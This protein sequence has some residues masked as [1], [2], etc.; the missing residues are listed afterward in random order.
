MTDETEPESADI[1]TTETEFG[2]FV[3]TPA[4]RRFVA[5]YCECMSGAEAARRA[6]YSKTTA[7][8]QASY[9]LTLPQIREAIE[10]RFRDAAAANAVT[11]EKIVAGAAHVAFLDPAKLYDESGNLKPWSEIDPATRQA[12]ASIE[13][14]EGEK[15]SSR[16][17]RFSDRMSALALLAKVKGLMA[18]E[19]IEVSGPNGDPI[20]LLVHQAQNRS[21]ITPVATIEHERAEG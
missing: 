16:R 8:K 20:A 4:R 21:T 19:K 14:S 17:V 11:V 9:L 13:E 1:A 5:E 12:I 18:P 6:G 2:G 10:A 7:R 3:W 15:G